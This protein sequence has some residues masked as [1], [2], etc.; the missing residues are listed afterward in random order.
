MIYYVQRKESIVNTQNEKTQDIFK[1]F[2]NVF[3]YYKKNLFWDKYKEV[4]EYT[5]TRILLCSSFKRI[6]KIKDK[7]IR[8]DLLN[9]N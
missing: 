4:L 1:V 7:T 3:E 5:Y 8:K 6:A 9:K 2:N